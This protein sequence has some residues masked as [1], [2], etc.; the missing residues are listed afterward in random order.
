MSSSSMSSLR[1]RDDLSLTLSLPRRSG[2]M[3]AVEAGYAIIA[4][5]EDG[6]GVTGI[7]SGGAPPL[8]SFARRSGGRRSNQ[9][10]SD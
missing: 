7:N 5:G 4:A 10:A 3:E 6:S 2:V 8:L 9:M 1:F